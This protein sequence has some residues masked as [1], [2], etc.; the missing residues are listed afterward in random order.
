[1]SINTYIQDHCCQ[2]IIELHEA[3]G[4]GSHREGIKESNTILRRIGDRR[5]NGLVASESMHY[6]EADHG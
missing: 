3:D 6:V 5:V 1:M 2:Q 4:S